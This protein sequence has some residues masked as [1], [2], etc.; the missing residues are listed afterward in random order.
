MVAISSPTLNQIKS[1]SIP[2]STHFNLI[3]FHTTKFVCSWC[4]HALNAYS[5]MPIC[6]SM[7]LHLQPNRPP[8]CGCGLY[9]DVDPCGGI[10]VKVRLTPRS[11]DAGWVCVCCGRLGGPLSSGL[12]RVLQPPHQHLAVHGVSQDGCHQPCSGGPR[13]LALCYRYRV[14]WPPHN[15]VLYIVGLSPLSRVVDFLVDMLLVD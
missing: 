1:W 3:F 12:C 6:Q 4:F 13:W 7:G 15:I 11:G 8:M 10:S 14:E 9:V 5:I 2:Y